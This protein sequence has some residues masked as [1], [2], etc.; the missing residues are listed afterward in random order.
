[1][2][3]VGPKRL[4]SVLALVAL[5]AWPA[6]VDAGQRMS[7]IWHNTVAD[8]PVQVDFH[9]TFTYPPTPEE[10]K[11]VEYAIRGAHVVLCDAT[12]GKLGFGTVLLTAGVA[13]RPRAD[14]WVMPPGLWSNSS[15]HLVHLLDDA[16]RVYM[17]SDPDPTRS[18]ARSQYVWAHEMA[19]AVLDLRDS[20]DRQYGRGGYEGF[21]SALQIG[22]CSITGRLCWTGDGC[23]DAESCIGS[24]VSPQVNSL[25]GNRLRHD[26]EP[27]WTC[28][29]LSAEC[30]SDWDCRACESLGV[31][32]KDD[33]DCRACESNGNP[34][35]SD[36]DCPGASKCEAEPTDVCEPEPVDRCLPHP[37]YSEFLTE[38]DY[39]NATGQGSECPGP[40]AGKIIELRGRTS[41]DFAEDTST[42][43]HAT[44]AQAEG[45]A[46]FSGHELRF[47]DE[48]GVV[49][50]PE[51]R[52]SHEI[53]VYFQHYS[54][55]QRRWKVY[56]LIDGKHLA[57]Q[58]QYPEGFPH[59]L[60]THYIDFNGGQ[61][62]YPPSG[63]D[64]EAARFCDENWTSC[65]SSYDYGSLDNTVYIPNLVNTGSD[66]TLEADYTDLVLREGGSGRRLRHF[67][68]VAE[69]G[70]SRRQQ[71]GDC[72]LSLDD[73]TFCNGGF[74][75]Q[76][77]D[78]QLDRW[79]RPDS[80]LRLWRHGPS[81]GSLPANGY[82]SEWDRIAALPVDIPRREEF[83]SIGADDPEAFNAPSDWDA[84]P[85]LPQGTPHAACLDAFEITVDTRGI[86][87]A[88]AVVVVMDVSG[89]MKKE[90]GGFGQGRT[91]ME[92]A[93]SAAN[94]YGDY[95]A[96]HN[97]SAGAT[98]KQ[99][100]GMVS[101]STEAH[102]QDAFD[103]TEL[104]G[105]NIS[106]YFDA[107][108]ALQPGG[109]TALADGIFAAGDMLADVLN[110]DEGSNA[111]I[112]VMTDGR[113]NVCTGEAQ[114]CQDSAT[115][116][117][118]E[119]HPIADAIA[120]VEL[121]FE[122]FDKNL[123]VQFVPL[124]GQHGLGVFSEVVEQT[125]GEVHMAKAGEDLVIEFTR[126][127]LRGFGMSPIVDALRFDITSAGADVPIHVEVDA[128]E[129]TI[130]LAS[131]EAFGFPWHAA[132]ELHSPGGPVYD[133]W[134]PGPVSVYDDPGG[135]GYRL[136]KVLLP[137][138]GTWEM[139][140]PTQ[141]PQAVTL[142]AWTDS[143]DH[144]CQ[145][146]TRY[147]VVYTDEDDLEISVT[148]RWGTAIENVGYSVAVL[149]PDGS[150][151]VFVAVDEIAGDGVARGVFPASE[152]HGRGTYEVRAF[153]N[154][155]DAWVLQ[156]AHTMGSDDEPYLPA[157]PVPE[158]TRMA[159]TTF[160]VE[161]DQ[162]GWLPPGGNCNGDEYSD[163]D[164]G[165]S[166]IDGW[167]ECE[168]EPIPCNTYGSQGA[169]EA[170]PDCFWVCLF[171]CTCRDVSGGRSCD[172]FDEGDCDVADGCDWDVPYPC[173]P[174]PTSPDSNGNGVIDACDP[175]PFGEQE[176][177]DGSGVVPGTCEELLCCPGSTCADGRGW[178]W[179]E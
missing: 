108:D 93:Q 76:T 106:D 169:C 146:S 120:A 92:W 56:Y 151:P 40:F 50:G 31:P 68:I 130:L 141:D 54:Q 55:S 161:I 155:Q 107:V 32:C 30:N 28:Q 39:D 81:N 97:A 52:S 116:D 18:S 121:L 46:A 60:A 90:A 159:T 174:D 133:P 53:K 132:W 14:V 19:H 175:D 95:V 72:M 157:I 176:C 117:C 168:G 36:D 37:Y 166:C 153:C 140:F 16:S 115:C 129:L 102:V 148:S 101:F 143:I 125:A 2:R 43:E 156:D 126:A 163:E 67:D 109:W 177:F 91:R 100:L 38:D 9:A 63:K 98:E 154:A 112:V 152:F 27:G 70:P 24:D 134:E 136:F 25:M 12:D 82:P 11:A 105:N 167:G 128:G 64:A 86:E 78:S 87:N 118:E 79:V 162:P 8:I 57:G 34:C 110:A 99:M 179:C 178:A 41:D 59:L 49:V 164:Y 147:P 44:W 111:A 22:R 145:V 69:D 21:G 94:A 77:Y 139:R 88:D 124:G 7:R 65:A 89:S 33:W 71:R 3:G 48:D 103:L 47:I 1:L 66:W 23:D 51:T 85:G 10:V 58:Q 15:A 131:R 26:W 62:S 6:S 83:E 173:P 170:Q 29:S 165:A 114:P 74:C 149:R 17:M 160:M 119:D 104:D 123:H 172:V 5:S 73:A 4:L 122:D 84:P 61:T 137:E 127:Y 35:K 150:L 75:A 45:S 113:A 96:L 42:F 13:A 144:G 135:A 80:L 20:Y 171:S 142:M 158:F 138:G